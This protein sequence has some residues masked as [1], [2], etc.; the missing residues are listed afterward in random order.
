[1]AIEIMFHDWT[2]KQMP[3]TESNKA[4]TLRVVKRWYEAGAIMGWELIK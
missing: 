1:M 3:I 4:E 2:T